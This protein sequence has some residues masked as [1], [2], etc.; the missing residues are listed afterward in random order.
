MFKFVLISSI[1]VSFCKHTSQV[2]QFFV[3]YFS[4]FL[5]LFCHIDGS[6]QIFAKLRSPRRSGRRITTMSSPFLSDRIREFVFCLFRFYKPILNK[7]TNISESKING[8]ESSH[9]ALR[10][11]L[12]N[13]MLAGTNTFIMPIRCNNNPRIVSMIITIYF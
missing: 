13:H 8:L 1:F 2:G 9:I 6:F 3:I 12:N 4:F 11:F 7:T 10:T 5:V